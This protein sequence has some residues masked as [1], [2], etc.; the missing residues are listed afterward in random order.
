MPNVD[1]TK[2]T[3]GKYEASGTIGQGGSTYPYSYKATLVAESVRTK[4]LSSKTT[5]FHNPNRV[6]PLMPLGFTF[7][8]DRQISRAG[9]QRTH[10]NGKATDYNATNITAMGVMVGTPDIVM[11]YSPDSTAPA[12]L[13]SQCRNALLA[14][15]KGLKIN[16]MQVYAERAKT[17]DLIA[18]TATK[19]AGAIGHLKRGDFASAASAMGGI[20]GR[21]ARARFNKAFARDSAKA[22]G[23][24]WLE[25]QYGWKPLLQ[26]VY[27]ACETLARVATQPE[28]VRLTKSRTRVT[29]LRYW[30]Q[31]KSGVSL[32]TTRS[33]TGERRTTVKYGVTFYKP[34]SLATS[35]A[36]V[37]ITNPLSLAWELMPY[38]FVVDWFLPVGSWIDTFDATLGLSFHSGYRTLFSKSSAESITTTFGVSGDNHSKTWATTGRYEGV[39]CYRTA[40]SDFPS[41][42][43]PRFKDP[44]SILHMTNALA[45]L[46]QSFGR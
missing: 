36:S 12:D 25:L 31:S 42:A 24:G 29:P 1:A 21:R 4:R 33:E 26:D 11:A 7:E 9:V 2:V 3:Y 30:S 15:I 18:S 22:L 38:S 41:P 32:V 19:M 43:I 6:G 27:G 16:L 37:G 34:G 20:A 39:R 44:V 14:D 17:A 13:E 46:S 23:S 35:M 28:L 45:L 10:Y 8:R 40:L 5:G